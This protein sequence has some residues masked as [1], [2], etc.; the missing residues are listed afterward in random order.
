MLNIHDRVKLNTCLNLKFSTKDL[1]EDGYD[2]TNRQRRYSLRNEAQNNIL[3]EKVVNVGGRPSLSEHSVEC[4]K[5]Y[6]MDIS[7]ESRIVSKDCFRFWFIAI[8]IIGFCR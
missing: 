2:I 3:E 8:L 1:N 5:G 4:V 7:T 6:L